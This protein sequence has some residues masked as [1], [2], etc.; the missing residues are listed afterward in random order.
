VNP[1]VYRAVADYMDGRPEVEFK[2][3]GE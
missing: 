3:P 1:A 2:K